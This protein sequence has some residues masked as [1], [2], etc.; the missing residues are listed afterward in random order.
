MANGH[1]RHSPANVQDRAKHVPPPAGM[2]PP[3]LWEA[4]R[5]FA[6]DCRKEFLI[7]N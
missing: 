3:V 4:R 2:T 6:S 5:L 7:F 1:P